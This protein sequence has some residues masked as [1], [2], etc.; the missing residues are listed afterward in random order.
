MSIRRQQRRTGSSGEGYVALLRGINVGGKNLLPMERLGRMFEAAGCRDVRTYI[1]SGNVIFKAS[2]ALAGRVPRLIAQA[3]AAQAGLEV[4][5]LVRGAEE[6]A[7]VVRA[8]PFHEGD[9]DPKTLHVAFLSTEPTPA[10]V[11]ALDPR[12]S[13]PDEFVVRGREIYLRLP[14]GVARTRLTNA[15]F[16]GKLETVSTLRGVGTIEKLLALCRR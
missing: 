13:P 15:Y 8:N 9:V 4:P 2:A 14:N 11:A 6:L 3:I 16:D 12:R 1:Q 7:A 10:Q 5:V